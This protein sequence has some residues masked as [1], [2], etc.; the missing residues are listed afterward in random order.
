MWLDHLLS[1]EFF[2]RVKRTSVNGTRE[3]K[4]LVTSGLNVETFE[5]E[6]R[7]QQAR[8]I[9]SIQKPNISRS[10]SEKLTAV[11]SSFNCKRR[12]RINKFVFLFCYQCADT[13][14]VNRES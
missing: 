13:D 4:E 14:N 10:K 2:G 11:S 8:K 6:R 3:G 12:L 7:V 9:H 1:R 5:S